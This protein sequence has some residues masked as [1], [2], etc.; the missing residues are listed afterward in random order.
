MKVVEL[1]ISNVRGIRHLVITPDKANMVIW[2]SN[3]S[4]KSAVVDA[5]DFLLTGRI[6]R[7]T[8]KG[9]G[10]LKLDVH[11]VH[12]DSKP[13]EAWVRAIVVIP[14]HDQPIEFKRCIDSP[15]VLQFTKTTDKKRMER[16]LSIALRG[17]H[18]LTRREILKFIT[19][20]PGDR[21]QGIQAILDLKDVEDIR[22]TL[23]RAEHEC[24]REFDN[25]EGALAI[26]YG[27]VTALT[28][29]KPFSV[30]GTLEE[31][32]KRRVLLKADAIDLLESAKVKENVIPPAAAPSGKSLNVT[33]LKAD[34][35]AFKA[36]QA[37]ANVEVLAK[38]HADLCD[39][40]LFVKANPQLLK[41][42]RRVSVISQS[43]TL[44]EDD[45]ACPVCDSPW[46]AGEL[47]KH[48]QAHLIE[49]ETAT[50]RQSNISTLSISLSNSLAT[51]AAKVNDI[52]SVA[53]IVGGADD[54]ALLKVWADE[55]HKMVKSLVDPVANYQ[56]DAE[57]RSRFAEKLIVAAA[58]PQLDILV[59][60][61]EKTFPKTTPE[62]EAWDWLTK[63]ETRLG[64]V[65]GLRKQ[66]EQRGL[67]YKRA[68]YMNQEFLATR[69]A[70]LQGLYDSVRDRF[71]GLYRQ[72]HGSDEADF[73]ADL[74][75]DK[76][77]IDFKVDF[78][79]RG[80]HPP[81]ALHSEGHQDS[82]GLCLYLAL[83]ERLT[84]GVIDLIIL[85]DVVMSVDADHRRNICD[86]LLSS[87]PDNQFL[88]TTHDR[89]WA[90]QL[91]M[92]KV[93]GPK[94]MIHFYNWRVATGPQIDSDGDV[95]GRIAQDLAKDD[96]SGAAGK[97]RQNS[98]QYFGMIC[99]GIQAPVV[100]RLNGAY[101]LGQ[102]LSGAIGQYKSL[103][104]KAKAAAQSWGNQEQFEKLTELESVANGVYE[105]TNAEK[106]PLNP[107]IHYNNWENFSK[108]DFQPV[109][110]SFRDLYD[111]FTC[112]K[113]GG[114]L[115]TVSTG[116][117]ADAVTCSC[118]Q[119]HWHLIP[120]P[121]AK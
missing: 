91:R 67:T 66:V 43:L 114:P 57:S 87:F 19:A 72:I 27:E 121:K 119:V 44:I 77:G 45:G 21:A 12:I 90:N 51:I 101:D 48:L 31:I 92:M 107:A 5:I 52:V 41:S 113:C 60:T 38:T 89:T 118:G 20:E 84:K 94:G 15:N 110:D 96:V 73:Q 1:E 26:A 13:N 17:Q 8:G 112:S 64:S 35:E 79:G 14:G 46:P 16:I 80:Q 99:D 88:I 81:H 86:L 74:R 22:A 68:S 100:F 23:V 33:Q 47:R 98:E 32:N 9:A 7:L 50:Q 82:M 65:G 49:A 93:V 71:V 70:V 85:D 37:A 111:I 53:N 18:V 95:W 56:T 34:T 55:I 102:L 63:I 2:G 10:D 78:Y 42:L 61:A 120:K 4:G 117:E 30:T 29:Q 40:I 62:V 106:W 103:L 105:R 11:G 76:A 115:R 104:R 75:P 6:S 59:Q 97:L 83:A 54:L 28:G 24:K 116:L 109:I 25:V 3:G 58:Q 36:F 39:Q 108:A 69:D